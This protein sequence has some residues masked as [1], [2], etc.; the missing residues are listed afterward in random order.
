MSNP[1]NENA[2]VFMT[3]DLTSLESEPGFYWTIPSDEEAENPKDAVPIQLKGPYPTEDAA[4]QAAIEFIEDALT[5]F[6]PIN[7]E[8]ENGL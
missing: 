7:Q 5:S 8:N 2:V 3:Y 1:L 4:S 6:G